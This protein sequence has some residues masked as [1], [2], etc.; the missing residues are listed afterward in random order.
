[1]DWAEQGHIVRWA[2]SVADS[3]GDDLDQ[4]SVPQLDRAFP[5]PVSLCKANYCVQALL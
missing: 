4:T 3:M 5:R 1:M 2:H